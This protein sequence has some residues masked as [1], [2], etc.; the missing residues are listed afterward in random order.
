M[1]D[2]DARLV[3]PGEQE[4][5][6]AQD[7]ALRPR[8]LSEFVGQRRLHE[9][10]GV[11]LD[12]TRRRGEALDHVLL[13]GPP[14][15]GKTT[16]AQI[17]AAELG[18]PLRTTSGPAIEHQG[19]LA[20]ILTGLEER[21]VLFLDE[22][23]RLS[24][25]VEEALYPAME[26]FAFDYV[27]GKGAGAQAMRLTLRRFTVIGATTRAGV[28]GGPL[29]DRFGIVLRVDFYE[30]DELAAIV[31]RS[32]RLLGVEIDPQ[33]ADTLASRARGTP[34]IVNRLLRRARDFAEVRADGRI[35]QA[36]AVGALEML[37]VDEQGL[38]EL[39][40]SVLDALCRSYA[41]RPV[42]LQTLAVSVSEDPDTIEDV[43]EPFL[44]R[45]G[46][47]ARTAQ[48]RL[49]TAD[50]YRHCG[51]EPPAG[52][53]GAATPAAGADAGEQGRLPLG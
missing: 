3:G 47:I 41:G 10:L 20:S 19:M 51:L 25:P 40:R 39:D 5:E 17:V 14:G 46:Y 29:R 22:I 35:D 8:R 16:L 11:L 6:R 43:V 45:L 42:G 4:D 28:L 36:V 27:L 49:A 38:D 18:V 31:R 30:V 9:Q 7:V 50:A 2:V 34:R 33:A 32:A 12:A 52:V 48:G 21:E 26:D 53:P 13:H 23:H 44:I 15:L 37:G 1:T 24:R